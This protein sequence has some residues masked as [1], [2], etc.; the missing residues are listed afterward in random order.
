MKA[1]FSD[2]ALFKRRTLVEQ[3]ADSLREGIRNGGLSHQLPPERTLCELLHASRPV[4]RRAI[5]RLRDEG[6]LCVRRGQPT[7]VVAKLPERRRIMTE[8]RVVLLS[9]DISNSTS[10][11][12]LMVIDEMRRVFADMGIGFDFVVEPALGKRQIESHLERLVKSYRANH[13]V[14]AGT[15]AA[16]QNWFKEKPLSVVSMGNSFPTTRLPFVN[17]NLHGVTRHA[18]GVFLGL[19]HRNIVFLMRERTLAGEVLEEAGFREAFPARGEAV[20]RV[21]KHPGRVDIIRECLERIFALEPATTAL[22]VSHAEDTLAVMNWC[23]ERG[24]RIPRDVSLISFEWAPFLEY[25]RPLPAWYFTNPKEHARKL[26]RLVL[27][28]SGDARS[29]RLIFPKFV[30]NDTTIR[31]REI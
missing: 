8:A 26:C 10:P 6:L 23:W 15:P 24:I 22:L 25:L 9:P 5:H 3:I 27:R 16:V 1:Q 7:K 13:W 31:A 14:L 17:D 30:K 20:G 18:A 29:P 11:W 21:I 2:R 4:V 28:P 12:F 19:G